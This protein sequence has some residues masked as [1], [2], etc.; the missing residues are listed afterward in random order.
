VAAAPIAAAGCGGWRPWLQPAGPAPALTAPRA[1][2]PPPRPPPLP[3]PPTGN[4]AVSGSIEGCEAVER[5]GKSFKARMTVSGA[6]GCGAGGAAAGPPDLLDSCAR[7]PALQK[8]PPRRRVTCINHLNPKPLQTSPPPKPRLPGA[9]R[10][11]G[12]VPHELHGARRREAQ[13]CAGGHQDRDPPHPGHLQR[14]RAAPLRPRRHQGHPR[15][16]GGGAGHSG[17]LNRPRAGHALR[18]KRPH[19]HSGAVEAVTP[20]P[21]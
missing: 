2:P 8:Q 18:C 1:L 11:R 12:R 9:P 4:Y 19:A 15:A 7:S 20:G 14:R 5:L 3:P 21:A 16:A 6:R 17:G 13:G 10:R